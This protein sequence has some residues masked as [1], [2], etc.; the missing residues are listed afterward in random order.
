V[1]ERKNRTLIDMARMMLGEFKTPERFWSEAVNTACHAINRLYLY[2]LLK[3][4]SYELLT[5][6][7]PTFLTFV[8]L[9]ANVTFW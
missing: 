4:T 9:G 8:Y 1:V 3:K 7:N 2:R 6:K 5:G